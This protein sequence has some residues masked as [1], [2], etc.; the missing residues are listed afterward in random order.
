MVSHPLLLLHLNRI[1]KIL[2]ARTM[3]RRPNIKTEFLI[4]YGIIA[5]QVFDDGLCLL[6]GGIVADGVVF[7]VVRTDGV[8][9]MGNAINEHRV[10]LQVCTQVRGYP[11]HLVILLYHT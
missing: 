10:N 5:Q 3:N 7:A 9:T 8:I 6:N 4:A 1:Y 11:F 2:Y